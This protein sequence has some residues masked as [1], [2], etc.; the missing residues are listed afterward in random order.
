MKRKS[1]AVHTL[2]LLGRDLIKKWG[3]DWEIECEM[4][5]IVSRKMSRCLSLFL[6]L[7]RYFLLQ[8]LFVS[9]L[10]RLPLE[11]AGAAAPNVWQE[12]DDSFNTG[13]HQAP[14]VH[15]LRAMVADLREPVPV[16][17]GMKSQC[18]NSL[19]YKP[20][21][22]IYPNLHPSTAGSLFLLLYSS[23]SGEA[24]NPFSFTAAVCCISHS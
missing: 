1:I 6:V 17:R 22:P 11:P 19:N 18:V 24:P 3:T 16:Q 7:G 12:N 13:G 15:L 20:Y 21:L 4:R 5:I 9:G 2:I 23:H 14:L 8:L 10:Q